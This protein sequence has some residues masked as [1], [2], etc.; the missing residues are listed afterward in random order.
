M[1][2]SQISTLAGRGLSHAIKLKRWVGPGK[3][4]TAKG[5]LKPSQ[6]PAAA[7]AL[8]VQVPA[9]VRTA[10]DVPPIHWPWVAAEAAGLIEVGA[11]KAV[12]CEVD[13]DPAQLWLTGLDAVLA[14]E[15]H[16]RDRRGAC[17]LCR[18]V[19]TAAADEAPLESVGD[20]VEEY[21]DAGTAYKSFRQTG[22]LPV[23]EAVA[24]LTSFGAL[25]GKKRLT[26][27]GRWAHER[28]EARAPESVTPDLPAP[29]LL[30]RLAPLPEDE[31]WRL[32][33]RWF[34][35]RRPVYGAAQLLYAA[36]YAAPVE[37]VAAVDVVAG[38]GEEALPA[39]RNCLRHKNLRPHAMA[40]LKSWGEGRGVDGAQRRWLITEYALAARARRGLEDAFHYVRDSGGLAVLEDSDHS[41]ARE[42]HRALTAA[43]FRV[44]VQQL[45]ISR[46]TGEWWRVLVPAGTTLGALHEI[47]R[48][49]AGHRGDE[50]HE[51]E[52]DGAR[53]SDPFHGLAEHRD[54]HEIRLSKVFPRPGNG[55]SY[56][57]DLAQPWEY[58]ITCEKLLEPD[59]G[60][61]YP[62]CVSV[63]DPEL[64]RRLARLRMPQPWA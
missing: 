18:A 58:R 9:K 54:E 17:T 2:T 7:A 11:A 49:L 16:D 47:V 64:D 37:R 61:R 50:L 34:G 48:I 43:N 33:L 15:S 57:Y 51:F 53:Y 39:W 38:F 28:F 62:A 20:I 63:T 44:R 41:G 30:A 40:A 35:D 59:P 8:G 45:K 31:A 10:A 14:A 3:P 36:E 6:L 5:V 32:A 26:P 19:L 27:L 52:V 46:T 22:Q 21:E 60:V 4:V 12:A 24:L 25:D 29:E 1:T 13:G 42:L 23:E 56:A 55:L